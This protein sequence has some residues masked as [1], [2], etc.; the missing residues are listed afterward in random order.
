MKINKFSNEN[1]ANFPRTAAVI[2]DGSYWST[3]RRELGML[4]V[5]LTLLSEAL[6]SPAYRLRSYYFDGKDNQRQSFHD[7]LQFLPRFEVIL[8][9]VVERQSECPHCHKEIVSREQKRV[10]VQLAVQMVHLATARQVDMI[11]LVAGDRDFI[12]SLEIAKYAGVVVKLVHGPK[13]TTSTDLRFH[14]DENFELTQNY[15]SEFIRSDKKQK[16]KKITVQKVKKI[17]SVQEEPIAKELKVEAKNLL[18][19]TL[20]ELQ[21]SS[22]GDILASQLGIVLSKLEPNWKDYFKV[23]KLIN[24]VQLTNDSILVPRF[25][26]KVLIFKQKID[27]PPS[28][29]KVEKKENLGAEFLINSLNDILRA[30]KVPLVRLSVL[31]KYMSYKNPNWKKQYKIKKL[32]DLIEINKEVIY[33]EGQGVDKMVGNLPK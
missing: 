23:K 7:G 11:V 14:A 9:D 25:K 3:I 28:A 30:K 31:G 18:I 27:I 29:K 5:D 19:N 17:T 16:T 21:E 6:C 12:P 20:S 2:F 26:G 10:D 33:I 22:D 24:F 13:I 4:D 8:G 32:D 15:L 1:R